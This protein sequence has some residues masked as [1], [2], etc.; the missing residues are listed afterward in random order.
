M[1]VTDW[2]VTKEKPK[3]FVSLQKAAAEITKKH[4]GKVRRI[5]SLGAA[6]DSFPAEEFEGGPDP[7]TGEEKFPVKLLAELIKEGREAIPVILKFAKG[8]KKEIAHKALEQ[9][10]KKAKDIVHEKG[11]TKD[12]EKEFLDILRE[13]EKDAGVP[14]ADLTPEEE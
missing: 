10:L 9:I 7:T 14:E 5:E 13:I 11:S 3:G 6:V 1:K 4:A 8:N 2:A 12:K